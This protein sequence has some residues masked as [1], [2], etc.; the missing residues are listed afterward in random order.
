M[1]VNQPED[2]LGTI[3]A[4]R[5][6]GPPM[7]GRVLSTLHKS[8]IS[9]LA[10]QQAG[11]GKGDPKPLGEGRNSQ[12]PVEHDLGQ[13]GEVARRQRGQ[14]RWVGGTWRDTPAPSRLSDPDQRHEQLICFGSIPQERRPGSANNFSFQHYVNHST[15][16]PTCPWT[17]QPNGGDGSPLGAARTRLR[18][19]AWR[20]PQLRSWRLAARGRAGWPTRQ[21]QPE[22]AGGARLGRGLMPGFQR[23]RAPTV[24]VPPRSRT[25]GRRWR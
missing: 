17:A 11:G 3:W 6:Q 14:S 1:G 4:D 16:S 18:I 7:V 9:Q 22:P 20:S 12:W 2:L 23:G 21:T 15:N 25:G 13:S 5:R 8:G 10:D 19:A 24:E